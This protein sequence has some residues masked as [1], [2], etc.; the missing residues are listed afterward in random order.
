MKIHK[1][2]EEENG[3]E[4][5]RLP[6]TDSPDEKIGEFDDGSGVIRP[7]YDSS[8]PTKKVVSNE[9]FIRAW[10]GAEY[11]SEAAEAIHNGNGDQ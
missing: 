2:D 9:Q 1:T 4:Y 6:S 8:K 3:A 5:L 7:V 10:N 11:L